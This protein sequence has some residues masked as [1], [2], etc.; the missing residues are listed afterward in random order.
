MNPIAKI[1]IV[2]VMV[3]IITGNTLR[4]RSLRRPLVRKYIMWQ[5][6][7]SRLLLVSF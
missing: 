6:F 7:L 2:T 1:T 5:F 3:I 4:E